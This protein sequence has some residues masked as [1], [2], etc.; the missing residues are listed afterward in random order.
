MASTPHPR[1]LASL[2]SSPSPTKTGAS[3]W[4]PIIARVAETSTL[5]TAQYYAVLA[6]RSST[7]GE[8]L[9]PST[10]TT[11][12]RVTGFPFAGE[13]HDGHIYFVFEP[14]TIDLV[15]RYYAEVEIFAGYGG[16]SGMVYVKI[17][18]AEFEVVEG[19]A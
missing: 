12:G 2:A 16:G 1:L 3:L 11:P 4:P 6:I 13:A 18:T 8:A 19:D 9:A 15:G 17:R 10:C 14:V 7:S 5:P